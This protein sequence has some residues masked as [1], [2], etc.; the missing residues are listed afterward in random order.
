M[1]S[2]TLSCRSPASFLS[3]S[4]CFS[5]SAIGF[6]NSIVV[7]AAMSAPADEANAL[8]TEQRPQF[9]EGRAGCGQLQRSRPEPRPRAVAIAPAQLERG[10]AVVGLDDR[11]HII[12]DL[13]RHS[14]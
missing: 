12:H 14:G 7:A 1:V 6:S 13:G 11:T 4:I 3:S 5:S 10:G 2:V 8:W 9:C